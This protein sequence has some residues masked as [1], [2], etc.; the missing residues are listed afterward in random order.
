MAAV[1]GIMH[2]PLILYHFTSLQSSDASVGWPKYQVMVNNQIY[3]DNIT[4]LNLLIR[5][6]GRMMINT[7]HMMVITFCPC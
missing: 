3:I 1:V 6:S 4:L 2:T 5:I 7:S